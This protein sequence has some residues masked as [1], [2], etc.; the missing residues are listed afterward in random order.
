MSD[1]IHVVA[2]VLRD[3][4]G[5]VL[6]AQRPAGKHLA[7]LWEFPGGKCERDE[8]P[9]DALRRELHEELGVS[10]GA[11]QRLI[12]VPWRYAEKSICL[13]VYTVA[14]FRGEP[15]GREAQALRWATP[16]ELLDIPM[17]DADRPVVAALR[18]PDEYAIT[19]E[20]SENA[21]FLSAARRALDSGARLLQLRSK[22]LG[23]EDL[24]ALAAALH[25]LVAGRGAQLLL[26]DHVE[27]VKRLGLSGVHL[28]SGALMKNVCRPLPA[29]SWVGASCHDERE[30]EHAARIGVDFAVLG[31]VQNTQSHPGRAPLGWDRFAHLCAQAPFP[32]FALGGLRREDKPIAV[33]AGAQGI[34]GI[35]AFWGD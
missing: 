11:A 29:Q 14:E 9:R 18:L 19:P 28:S 13:D 27:L 5:R 21:G 12:A 34:A 3:A 30:L 32:V 8:D 15:H 2:G 16:Q 4:L 33:A 26:N 1:R 24:C 6:I 23:D 31:P 10:A 35:S 20:P 25:E 17:P 7:G 22:K